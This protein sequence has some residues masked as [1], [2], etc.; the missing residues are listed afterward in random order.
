MARVTEVYMQTEGR[1]VGSAADELEKKLA[2][3]PR[4]RHIKWRYVGEMELMRT[5][6]SGLGVAIGLAVM[7]VFMVM[8]IQFKSLRLPLVML[9]A[10]PV[11]LI[12]I[13]VA[14]VAAGQ[15]F[16][17]TALMGILMVIGIAV[18]N[19]I[20]LVA[21]AS[22][23]LNEGASKEEAIVAAA[24]T[25]FTPIMMTSLA[26]SDRTDSNGAR[27]RGW[28]R[29][30]PGPC[31]CGRR[32]PVILHRSVALSRPVDV[33]LACQASRAARGRARAEGWRSRCCRGLMFSS[34]STI[35]SWNQARVGVIAARSH[36]T[37]RATCGQ[38]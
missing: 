24:R 16:S 10:I 34:A 38:S 5:T 25:R 8:T 2:A 33:H 36:G 14:L 18:S 13:V 37:C 1:D 7:V 32:R 15:G 19:G 12:G 31:A 27:A 26:T 11:C 29:G 9:F 35:P 28:H 23:R 22:V 4:T 3:N 20:L 17:V 6:F 21:E 30:Q